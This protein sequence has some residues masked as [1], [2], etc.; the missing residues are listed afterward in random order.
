MKWKH[1]ERACTQT[2][3]SVGRRPYQW[4]T[5]CLKEKAT[6]IFND[7]TFTLQKSHSNAPE[8]EE[9]DTN[10]TDE[11]TF[12]KQQLGIADG[13]NPVSLVYVGTKELTE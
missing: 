13:E 5:L 2:I 8:L 6:E 3:L 4:E 9:T 7:A 1:Y 11:Q 12:A 10:I